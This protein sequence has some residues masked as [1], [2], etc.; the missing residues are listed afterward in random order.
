MM[1]YDTTYHHSAHNTDVT[2][3]DSQAVS[4]LV[5]ANRILIT[6]TSQSVSDSSVESWTIEYLYNCHHY[7]VSV[8]GNLNMNKSV[9]SE[10]RN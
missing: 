3:I 2:L 7:G 10:F 4:R 9:G 1:V 8:D 6:E 5:W